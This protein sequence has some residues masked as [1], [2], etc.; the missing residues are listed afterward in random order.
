MT[1]F[2]RPSDDNL[3]N[4]EFKPSEYSGPSG[5]VHLHAHTVFSTLDGVATPDQY[6]EQ[7]KK[8]GYPAM[9]ATEHGNMAS[10]PDMYFA[11]QKHGLKSI[12][13]CE[14]Y[15]NDHELKRQK[16]YKNKISIKNVEQGGNP[17]D[18]ETSQKMRRNRHLTVLARTKVGLHNLIKLTTLAYE[19][20]FYYQPRIWFNKLC[21]Y[22][23]GLLVLSGCLNGPVAFELRCYHRALLNDRHRKTKDGF[24]SDKD[25]KPFL[26]ISHSASHY[27]NNAV[28]YIKKFKQEFGDNYFIELQMP[29]L[30]HI[31]DN[32]VFET[33]I[34]LADAYKI[35][36]VLAN[37]SHY[38][39]RKDFYIQR[40]MMAISQDLPV[41]SPDLFHVNSDEQYMKSRPELWATFKNNI[42]S[43][44]VDDRTFEEMCDNTLLIADMIENIKIDTSPKI[45][46][47]SDIEHGQNADDTLRDIVNSELQKRSLDKCDKKFL[48]DGKDVTYKE[49][50]DIELDRFISKGFASYFLITR[51]LVNFGKKRGWPFGP[52]GSAGGSLVC[53]LLGI[54]NINPLPWGLSFDRF[55]SP[56]RG[57]FL[58]KVTMD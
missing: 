11:F 32:L 22:K 25:G 33:L 31:Y 15:Y 9:A 17:D 53:Y 13:G 47:W 45:P 39:Q 1:E 50:A 16:L 51:D 2:I 38:M 12:Q 30:H 44:N 55:L 36:I 42:Y 41:D 23:E 54:S 26:E 28:T 18:Y 4:L 43:K 21:E 27:L 46:N 37:D 48:I 29:G 6:A 35:K 7:C 56:S 10:V 5:F 57:G 40:V 14:I 52:R 58:L 20:G 8:R 34:E 24:V 3:D 19:W 49:Q